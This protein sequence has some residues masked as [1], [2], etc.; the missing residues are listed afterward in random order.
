MSNTLVWGCLGLIGLLG[1]VAV[2]RP[3][4]FHVISRRSNQWIDTSKALAP[5]DKQFDIDRYVLPYSRLMGMAVLIA[6][7]ILAWIVK[8]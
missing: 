2:V 3:R 7:A 5:L 4:L 6:V 1:M 8:H